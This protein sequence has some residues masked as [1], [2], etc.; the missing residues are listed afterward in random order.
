MN[1]VVK[2]NSI[3][4][5]A[6]SSTKN[7][8]DF[9][10]PAKQYDLTKSYLNLV[11]HLKST[12]ADPSTGAG[13]YNYRVK[14]GGFNFD[15][16]N[17]ALVKNAR[18]SSDKVGILEDI[19]RVD[20]YRCQINHYTQ[21][22]EDQ[23]GQ[24]YQKLFQQKSQGQVQRPI[25]TEFFATGSTKSIVHNTNVQIPMKHIFNLG[26]MDK[27]PGDAL[28]GSRVHLEM[29]F[30][31]I[32]VQQLQGAGTRTG[33][34][35][36]ASYFTE[37]LDSGVAVGD[38]GTDANPFI[39]KQTWDKQGICSSPYWVGQKLTFTATKRTAGTPDPNP[40]THTSVITEIRQV[41]TGANQGRLEI[42]MATPIATLGATE[43]MVD[44]SCDGVDAGSLSLQVLEAELVLSE[45]PQNEYEKMDQLEYITIKNEEDNGAGL[46][47]FSR[48]YQVE[49]N[50]FNVLVM[51][52]A[53]NDLTT[54]NNNSVRYEKYR[55]LN[56]NVFLT[57][58]DV[59]YK[60][61]LYYDQISKYL[62]NQRAPLKNLT[63]LVD[64]N[65]GYD[66]RAKLGDDL[67]FM[68]TPLPLTNN[69]KQVQVIID[70]SNAEAGVK[71]LELFKTCVETKNL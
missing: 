33:V 22:L 4:S 32:Q 47:N 10:L 15:A 44:V 49:G 65:E 31:K 24:A 51:P 5:G 50:C 12:D 21:N 67:F 20:S 16:P 71:K 26:A 64:N 19:R 38:F 39:T 42:V 54:H 35:F 70:G 46:N 13:V 6:F 8:L 53:D 59:E 40:T 36:G 34:Q 45:V 41:T 9:D 62:L 7:L 23:E 68:G 3:Q 28:N 29:N 57:N 61:P 58:R 48:Q 2:L 56:D 43:D 11:C 17:V 69:R 14:W 52:L 63:D 30:D 25:G 60:E 66:D 37:F 18:L 55:M 1:R 27:Y